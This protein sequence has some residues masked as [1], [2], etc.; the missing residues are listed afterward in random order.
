MLLESSI[1]RQEG[2]WQPISCREHLWTKLGLTLMGMHSIYFSCTLI[3]IRRAR[4]ST[5]NFARL[6][7]QSLS[8]VNKSFRVARQQTWKT[9]RPISKCSPI[10][11]ATSTVNSGTNYSRESFK[12]SKSA[13]YC[14]RTQALTSKRPF[15]SLK[16]T[17]TQANLTATS[18]ETIC[19][20]LWCSLTPISTFC[21][22]NSTADS[23]E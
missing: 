7:C 10:T 16:V 8:N 17:Q 2:K 1:Q 3:K 15:L 22:T 5:Q 21:S 12:L 4:W 20:A 13:S 18:Q 23:Q 6:S 19:H 9:S 11:L 14:S